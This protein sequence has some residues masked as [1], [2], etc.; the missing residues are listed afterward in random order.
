M[1]DRKTKVIRIGSFCYCIHMSSRAGI[2]VSADARPAQHHICLDKQSSYLTI[3]TCRGCSD[4]PCR[5]C[6]LSAWPDLP[7]RICSP[8]VL[9]AQGGA[10]WTCSVVMPR[11]SLWLQTQRQFWRGAWWFPVFITEADDIPQ[12]SVFKWLLRYFIVLLCIF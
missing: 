1:N 10:A 6:V 11:R 8:W 12:A 4:G 3:W 7:E 9:V 5:H 2:P